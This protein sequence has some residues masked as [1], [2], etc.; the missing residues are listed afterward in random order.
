[1]KVFYKTVEKRHVE[2]MNKYITNNS[3]LAKTFMEFL[4][5][6]LADFLKN[7]LRTQR[8]PFTAKTSKKIN[9]NAEN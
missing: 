5:R 4:T 2:I 1:M 9:E 6:T 3:H 8:S 7:I